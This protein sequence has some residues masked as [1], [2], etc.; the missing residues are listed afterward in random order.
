MAKKLYE[1]KSLQLE[2]K[3]VDASTGTVSGYFSAFNVADSYNDIMMPGAFTKT[4]QEQGPMSSRPRIKH[5]LNHDV[6]MPIGR[7]TTLKEDDYGLYYESQIGKN[8]AGEDYRKMIES[9]LITE[10]SIGFITIQSSYNKET[11]IRQLNEVKLF[12]GSSLT[13]WG[14]NQYTPLIGMK[15]AEEIDGRIK[16]LEKFCRNTD[17][18]DET[19]EMLLLEVRQLQ[20][21]LTEVKQATPAADKAQVPEAKAT[22]LDASLITAYL[23]L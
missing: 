4:I 17:A 7:L 23:S 16:R 5:L 2:V 11:D 1:Y 18:T 19:I 9:G 13:G 14:V 15:S 10:H 12:E 22:T 3:D 6:S 21:A 20:Q 8:A